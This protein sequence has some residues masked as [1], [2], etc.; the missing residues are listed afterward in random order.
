MSED[1]RKIML[2]ED[3]EQIAFMTVMAL[4][5]IGGFEVLHCDNGSAAIDAFDTFAPQVVLMD[6]MMPGMDGPDTLKALRKNPKAKKIPV[7][8][9]TAKVQAHERQGYFEIGASGVIAKPFDPLVLS[10]KVK[11]L[12][13]AAQ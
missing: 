1:L 7:I 4:E 2:V 11:D 10:Q 13:Q 5:E 3:D 6:V 8:F 12:W 9:M